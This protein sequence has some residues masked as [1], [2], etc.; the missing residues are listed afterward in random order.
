MLRGIFDEVDEHDVIDELEG[1]EEEYATDD[2][3]ES[4]ADEID[5][6]DEPDKKKRKLSFNDYDEDLDS[7][8][9]RRLMSVGMDLP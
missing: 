5:V 3:D 9:K 6:L 7:D 2:V 4:E 1:Y 8:E